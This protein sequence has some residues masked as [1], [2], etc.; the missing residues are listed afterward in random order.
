M[1]TPSAS[2]PLHHQNLP[3]APA[4]TVSMTQLT[5]PANATPP[6]APAD[7]PV[8]G[9]LPVPETNLPAPTGPA[10]EV[11]AAIERA[12]REEKTKLYADIEGLNARL[13]SLE[14]D[15]VALRAEN[16]RLT[17]VSKALE[18][19]VKDGQINVP[20]LV[21]ELTERVTATVASSE[22][23]RITKLQQELADVTTRLR[24]KEMTELR[25]KLIRDAGG[26]NVLIPE[27]VRG[28]TEEELRASVAESKDIFT[29]N[30][31]RFAPH[32]P[33]PQNPAG[34]QPQP[35]APSP[36]PTLPPA[37][38]TAPSDNATPSAS[39]TR[40]SPA[41]WRSRRTTALAEAATR[42]PRGPI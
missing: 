8:D 5:S 3:A 41:E 7:A 1:P 39:P 22:T 13:A 9:N 27:L 24:T 6:P 26:E 37:L 14:K 35:T 16:A 28:N 25:E 36:V 10:P 19:S 42:Y 40:V 31:A 21:E 23:A 32:T 12:R 30:I 33:A 18:S 15:N 38:P 20:K 17:T 34:P 2:A 29:R 11:I 4:P